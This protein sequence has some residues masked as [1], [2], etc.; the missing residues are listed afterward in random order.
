MLVASAFFDKGG[1]SR[2]IAIRRELNCPY[3]G[4]LVIDL[5]SITVMLAI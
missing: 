3:K 2:M 1:T 4:T 5:H